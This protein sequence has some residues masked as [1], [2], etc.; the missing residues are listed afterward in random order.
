MPQPKGYTL[1]QIVLHW[2]VFL[3][4]A[5]QFLF[6]DSISG[7]FKAF[8]RTG[9]FEPSAL[10]FAHVAG[11]GAILLLVIWRMTIKA[12]RGAP[13]LPADEP[14][15]LRIAAHF[16]HLGLYAL[17]ILTA[18]SGAMAWFGGFAWAGETHEVMKTLL[19]LLVILHIA[20]ALYQQLILKSDV[21]KR[22][23]RPE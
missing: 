10:V 8:L 23:G 22:M 17:L 6:S 1:L 16:A 19:M 15:L 9:S 3:L 18:F 20:G 7:A 13:P 21:M 4:V 12:K 5:L 2:L 11:G 14:P